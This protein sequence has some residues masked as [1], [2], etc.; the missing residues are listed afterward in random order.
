MI[1]SKMFWKTHLDKAQT[2]VTDNI[3]LA[4]AAWSALQ[5]EQIHNMRFN[6]KTVW[7]SVKVLA[8]GMTSHH[9]APTV[10]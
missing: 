9:K 4:K 2:E 6:P 5:A 7:E 8:G 3:S 10:M 1:G